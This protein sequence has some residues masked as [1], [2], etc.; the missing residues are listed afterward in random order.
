MLSYN[1]H[2]SWIVRKQANGFV[3]SF[4]WII[5]KQIVWMWVITH[6]E[7]YNILFLLNLT[8]A[9]WSNYLSAG[10]QFLSS[11]HTN[12]WECGR[13]YYSNVVPTPVVPYSATGLAIRRLERIVLYGVFSV[14]G[15]SVVDTSLS[16]P[17][18]L[19]CTSSTC[20]PLRV[21]R[22]F[23]Y[24]NLWSLFRWHFLSLSTRNR[25]IYTQQLFQ[26]GFYDWFK[27]ISW[28]NLCIW[29]VWQ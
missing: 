1:R 8:A 16:Y 14:V 26:R 24:K 29:F 18:V 3:Q 9:Y 12:T 20:F 13:Y 27:M 25:I 6:S 7:W 11:L 5:F 28:Q 19:T 10:N 15:W 21:V 17:I 4:T 22:A 2:P 23:R